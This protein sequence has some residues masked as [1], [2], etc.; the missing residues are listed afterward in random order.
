MDVLSVD[1]VFRHTVRLWPTIVGGA[2]VIGLLGA[3]VG[4]G[5]F[6]DFSLIHTIGQTIGGLFVATFGAW[7]VFWFVDAVSRNGT[8][9]QGGADQAPGELFVTVFVLIYLSM[10][11]G[12]FFTPEPA[13]DPRDRPKGYVPYDRSD[14]Y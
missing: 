1:E 8:A 14:D 5:D 7:I 11:F 12:G 3:K 6:E 2:F 10:A 9:E 13:E 4:D